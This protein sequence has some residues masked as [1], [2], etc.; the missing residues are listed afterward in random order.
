MK[1]L[2]KA[3]LAV[4]VLA[5]VASAETKWNVDIFKGSQATNPAYRDDYGYGSQYTGRDNKGET[6]MVDIRATLWPSADRP[7]ER[8]GVILDIGFAGQVYYGVR[9]YNPEPNGKP[10]RNALIGSLKFGLYKYQIMHKGERGRPA[11]LSVS[12]PM[13]FFRT[14]TFTESHECN[15]GC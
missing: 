3:V 11:S 9:A 15:S 10:Q 7:W 12:G 14:C 4:V 2:I 5:G 13:G 8:E 6:C 1:N